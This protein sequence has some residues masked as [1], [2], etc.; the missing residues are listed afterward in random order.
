MKLTCLALYKRETIS[1]FGDVKLQQFVDTQLYLVV[2]DYGK[3][4]KIISMNSDKDIIFE[5][6]KLEVLRLL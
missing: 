1:K 3:K 2:K 5:T 6:Y 4:S